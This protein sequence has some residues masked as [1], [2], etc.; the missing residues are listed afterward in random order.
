MNLILISNDYID[1]VDDVNHFLNDF[2]SIKKQHK[3]NSKVTSKPSISVLAEHNCPKAKKIQTN[4]N[5]IF[6]SIIF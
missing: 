4:I 3:I 2:Y 1:V 5:T 6:Y